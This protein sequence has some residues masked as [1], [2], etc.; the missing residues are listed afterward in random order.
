MYGCWFDE[1]WSEPR[2]AEAGFSKTFVQHYLSFSDHPG[3]LRG[4]HCQVPTA[5]Q[6]K[7]MDT[8]TDAIRDIIPDMREDASIIARLLATQLA[9]NDTVRFWA[10]P[11]FLH[12]SITVT[13]DTRVA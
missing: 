7:L 2:L 12:G 9:A 6:D 3:A 10:P 4:L 8:L 5:A 11:G 13:P 1:T